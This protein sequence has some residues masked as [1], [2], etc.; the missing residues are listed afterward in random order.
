MTLALQSDTLS[1]MK[2][3]GMNPEGVDAEELNLEELRKEVEEIKRRSRKI[4][5][6]IGQYT[7]QKTQQGISQ[8]E[9]AEEFETLLNQG[10]IS[11][12]K[13]AYAKLALDYQVIP[14]HIPTAPDEE[15]DFSAYD[16]YDAM[17]N[18]KNTMV[19][20]AAS[21][22]QLINRIKEG[23][24]YWKIKAAFRKQREG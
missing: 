7:H 6:K 9:I 15:L 4:Y 22:R 11:K 2:T 5:W 24:P 16:L 18:K 1:F 8:R 23:E 10:D 17:T 13:K 19:R 20:N 12:L 21:A 3:N 14:Q